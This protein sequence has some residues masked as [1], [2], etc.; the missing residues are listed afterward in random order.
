MKIWVLGSLASLALAIPTHSSASQFLEIPLPQLV[1]SY[2]GAETEV[3]VSVQ[4][5]FSGKSILGA[6]LHIQGTVTVGQVDCTDGTSSTYPMDLGCWIGDS[7]PT[8]YRAFGF[9]GDDPELDPGATAPFDEE[10]A[11]A[12]A[13]QATGWGFL[14][15]G[16]APLTF[17]FNPPPIVGLCGI[18]L[19]S[20]GTITGA[21]LTVEV[22]SSVPLTEIRWSA[23]KATY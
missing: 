4:H 9:V 8:S 16:E 11:L 14:A 17:S 18:T 1:G 10:L 3:M 22:E 12:P 7:Y 6:R 19:S 21:T 15:D 23:L 13:S 5:D 20:S 2:P